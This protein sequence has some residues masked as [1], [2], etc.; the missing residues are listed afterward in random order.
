VISGITGVSQELP[1]QTI[2]A[3]YGDA[4]LAGIARGLVETD[5]DWSSISSTVEPN[6]ETREVYDELYAIYR[7][8]YPATRPMAHALAG[9]QTRR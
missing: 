8:L 3:S 6:P 4:K 1:E 2:G 5:A 9:M 7:N